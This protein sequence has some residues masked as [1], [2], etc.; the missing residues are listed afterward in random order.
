[1]DNLVS[2]LKKLGLNAYEAK[3][4]LALLRKQP[5]TGYEVSKE[6]DIPQARAYDTLKALEVAQVV[7]ALQ[8]KPVTYMPISPEEL[9][10]RWEMDFNS[11]ISELREALPK[12]ST[13]TV[14]PV[15]NLHGAASVHKNLFDIINGAKRCI[16]MELWQDDS[17]P[18]V[19]P[20][21]QAAARGVDIKAIGYHG[22]DLKVGDVYQHGQADDIIK[23]HKSRW[24]ILT[25]D[26]RVGMV[27]AMPIDDTR[28]PSAVYTQ[29]E[30]LVLVMN[31]LVVHDLFILDI[32]KRLAGPISEVYGHNRARIREKIFGNSVNSITIGSH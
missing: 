2:L 4:Y 16:M 17:A 25:A 18:L 7:I 1:M 15:I 3:V 27:C 9:L 23:W 8:G 13:E 10:K 26:D 19:P 28:T 30:S 5:A 31:E 21:T 29:N 22:L 20:L 6:A 12:V 32:E 11:S 14:E 24:L